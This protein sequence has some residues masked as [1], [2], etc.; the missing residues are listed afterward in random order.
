VLPLNSKKIFF[1]P[2]VLNVDENNKNSTE[3]D[4][5]LRSNGSLKSDNQAYKFINKLHFLI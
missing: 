2:D 4:I 3:E 1:D 5:Y